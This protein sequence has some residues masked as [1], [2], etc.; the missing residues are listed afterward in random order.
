MALRSAL[1]NVMTLA[2]RKAAR[3]LARD[4]GEV[5]NL[6]VSKKGPSNFVTAADLRAESIL[7]TELERVRPGYGF[8]L[9]EAGSIEGNDKT[10][11]WLV[12]P[13]DGTTNFLH[14]LPH[15][16]ISIALEREGQLVAG[17][18]YD[19]IKDETFWAEKGK[20]AFLNDR[21]LRVATRKDLSEA[22]L[23]TGIPFHGR[24]GHDL[25]SRELIAITDK[26]AGIRR[27]GSAALD[28]AYVSAGRYDGFWE[29]GLAPW[30][31]AAG[32][33]LVCEAGGIVKEIDGR[34]IRVDS[35]SI[36]ASNESL[37][38]QV[39]DILCRAE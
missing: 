1:I 38:G 18:I 16:A 9:E 27:Y 21:R 22:L 4:F 28:L 36:L 20:G 2:T 32:I 10:H 33:V 6:Q 12:D 34:D 14:G 26:I 5:E 15:F 11:R 23:A 3:G 17:V 35:P 25:M 37:F 13:L 29:R 7:Q 19:P 31:V 30:D 24:P 39:S 8:L